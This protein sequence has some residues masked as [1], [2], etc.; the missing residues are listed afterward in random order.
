[1]P[2]ELHAN[3]IVSSGRQNLKIQMIKSSSYSPDLTRAIT[4]RFQRL[5]FQI[6]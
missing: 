4:R 6:L 1:M 5:Y 3:F 2:A